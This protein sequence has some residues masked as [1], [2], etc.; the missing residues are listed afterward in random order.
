MKKILT[1]VLLWTALCGTAFSQNASDFTV[2][3]NGV[4][5]KY[6]G[7][8]TD[9]KIPDTIG[10]KKVTA[11]GKEAFRK[12][13]LT[14]VTI[15]AGIVS[16]GESAFRENKLTAVTIP[17][18]VK[19]IGKEAFRDNTALAAIVIPQGVET[20][21]ESAFANTKC[22]SI[23]LPSSLREIG[24]DAFDTSGKPSFTL[25]AN[26][27]TVF[28]TFPAFYAYIA[29]DRK[30]GTYESDTQADS[31]TADDYEYRETQY[32]AVLTKYTG[33]STRVRIPAEIGGIAVKALHG[34]TTYSYGSGHTH[35]GTFENKSLDA[36]QIPD[37]VTYIGKRAFSENKLASVAIP[38]G[39]TYIGDEA[40][41]RNQL[42]SITIPNSVMYLSGFNGNKLTSVTI[43][44]SVTSI[45]IDA[46]YDNQLTS[47]TI[48]NSVT[49]IGIWAFNKNK[50]TSVTIPNS[51]TYIGKRAFAVNKL[52]SVTIGNGV[53]YIGEEAFYDNNLTNVT[54]PNSVTSI[55]DAAFEFNPSLV[56]FTIGSNVAMGIYA[57]GGASDTIY[58]NGGKLAGTYVRPATNNR[59]ARQ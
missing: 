14:S 23:S 59:W 13:D 22:A 19:E 41:Y 50:L 51:V 52:T 5:T 3:A 54:I 30:A 18:S 4:I 21:G 40:F 58:N 2:D 57:L 44:N 28:D 35:N 20:I 24:K 33:S 48:P 56:R 34:I 46:F 49:S 12:A 55:G 15:P 47:V 45:G 26:V 6:T 17:G 39:V 36:V 37:S 16:I 32:G 31:K 7:F 42:T 53:T 29:N 1:V 38:N 9:I 27:N 43:P 25:A 11:I 10:G 8:D